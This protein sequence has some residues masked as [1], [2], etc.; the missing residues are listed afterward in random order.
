MEAI[1]NAY[2]SLPALWAAYERTILQ[3]VAAGGDGITAARRMLAQLQLPGGL[4]RV[5][6]ARSQ[7]VYDQLFANG[8]NLQ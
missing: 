2:P 3:T 1:T 4:G 8:A 6:E 5:G 7:R